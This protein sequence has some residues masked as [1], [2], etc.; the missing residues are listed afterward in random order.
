MVEARPTGQPV[1]IEN[2]PDA[3][4]MVADML[5][6]DYPLYAT[7]VLPVPLEAAQ[8]LVPPG[9][10]VHESVG[11]EAT[12]VTLGGNDLDEL[13]TRLLSLAVPL[14]VVAPDELRDV[15]R[16]RLRAQFD[17]L[18]WEDLARRQ[19]GEHAE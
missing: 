13:A 2:P 9:S 15:L 1:L 12:R 17:A 4:R 18:A 6:S 19:G 8:R 10:G 16:T 14:A 11:P 7:V 5:T 3:A